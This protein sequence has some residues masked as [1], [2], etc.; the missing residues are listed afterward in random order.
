MAPKCKQRQGLVEAYQSLVLTATSNAA[1][2]S[3]DADRAF[4]GATTPDPGAIGKKSRTIR[5]DDWRPERAYAT[6]LRRRR[7]RN[8]VPQLNMR[9]ELRAFFGEAW[10]NLTAASSH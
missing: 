7:S 5:H 2:S 3:H 4:V 9:P 8:R 1:R 6:R 10:V